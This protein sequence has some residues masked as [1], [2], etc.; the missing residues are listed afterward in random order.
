MASGTWLNCCGIPD[1]RRDSKLERE[2]KHG[3]D[4]VNEVDPSRQKYDVSPRAPRTRRS[5]RL[6]SRIS[7]HASDL[8][9]LLLKPELLRAIID[10]G[11]ER[12]ESRH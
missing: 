12:P 10:C 5:N 7:F 8:R 4:P 11:F 2:L 3:E 1:A 9:D 6:R